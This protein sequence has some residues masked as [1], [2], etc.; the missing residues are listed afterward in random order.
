MLLQT[1]G[2]G[3]IK[4]PLH[5][6]NVCSDIISSKVTVGLRPS[7]PVKGVSMILGN[8]VAGDRVVGNPQVSSEAPCLMTLKEP[9]IHHVL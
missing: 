1:V 3:V 8:D 5:L 9:S 2:M 4:V 7:L 6:I